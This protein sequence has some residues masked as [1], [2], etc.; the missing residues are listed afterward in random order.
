MKNTVVRTAIAKAGLYQWQIADV[1][2]ISEGTLTRWLR[3]E[4]SDER[5]EKVLAAID[6]LT[7]EIQVV[8][9]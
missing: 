9:K 4:L 8:E 7:G 3:T 6:R 2:G 5:R 1:I